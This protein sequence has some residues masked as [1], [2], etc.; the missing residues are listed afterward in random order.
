MTAKPSASA[1][2]LLKISD[3][4]SGE[5]E[6]LLDL[7]AEMKRDPDGWGQSLSGQ[8]LALLFEKPSTRTRVSFAAAAHRLGLLPL[9]LHRDELQLGRGEAIADTARVLSAYCSG[10]VIRTYAQRELEVIADAATIPVV[11]ALSDQ[12]HPCQALAD[13]LTV[14]ERFGR[15]AGLRVAYLGDGNNVACSLVEAAARSGV[16]IV[17]GCPLG[18]EP[19]PDLLADAATEAERTG[20]SVHLTADAAEAA[21]GAD[22][23]Y[24]DVWASMGTEAERA[25]RVAALEPY[26]VDAALM[27]HASPEAVFLHCLPAHRGE[28]VTAEVIDGPRSAVWDQAANRLPTEQAVLHHLLAGRR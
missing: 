18:Y 1:R 9:E 28:E 23:V 25:E 21:L 11:N 27:S 3:L 10:L 19:D 5:L 24:T 17:L 15:L 14:R 8:T 13:L 16:H 2:D 26:R 7:A 6:H 22:A 12:H 4:S 20:G